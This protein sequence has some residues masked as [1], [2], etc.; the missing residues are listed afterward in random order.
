[1]IDADLNAI[2][3]EALAAIRAG[4]QL[5]PFTARRPGLTLRDAYRITARMRARREADGETVVGRKIGFTNHRIWDEYGVHAPIW[6]YV[7]TSTLAEPTTPL[8]LARLAEPKIEPEIMFGLA[9][10]PAPDM[11]ERALLGCIDWVAHGFEIVQSIYP[12]WTFTAV[13]T[14][15]ANGLHGALAV[16]ARR[17]VGG[18]VD[19]WLHAL[20]RFEI[21]LERDGAPVDAGHASNVLGGPLKALLHLV[22][23]LAEDDANSPLAAGDIVSTGTLTRAL[24]VRPG[25]TWTTRLVGVA[26]PGATL[27]LAA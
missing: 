18:D 13:D 25:E 1:M 22:R 2:A 9:R 24:A 14:V 8:R 16:G 4:A 11:D 5:P 19:E 10:A 17:P 26:L 27:T 6:G 7:Y 21:T 15:L 12:D 20:D 23:L 3:D